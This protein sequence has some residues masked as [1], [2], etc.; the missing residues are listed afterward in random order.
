MQPDDRVLEIGCGHGVAVTSICEKLSAPGHVTALDRSAKMIA[1]ARARN[2]DAARRGIADFVTAE[3]A[4]AELENSYYDK[5]LGIHV[6][7]FARGDPA[8]EFAALRACLAPDG[9]VFLS[10]Q[11]LQ[12]STMPSVIERVSAA[13][14][15]NG[16]DVDDVVT[17]ELSSGWTVCLQ[18]SAG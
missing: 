8:S 2:A 6:P 15:G 3:L 17:E 18:L 11:P 1:A 7:V 9:Q 12:A 13:A 14:T 4:S 5:V 10:Y 16:F